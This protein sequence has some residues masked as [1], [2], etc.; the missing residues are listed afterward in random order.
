MEMNVLQM[1]KESFWSYK[2]G[3]R[4]VIDKHQ[5]KKH[6]KLVYTSLIQALRM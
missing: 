2:K 1:L 4:G 6:W 3:N 5:L